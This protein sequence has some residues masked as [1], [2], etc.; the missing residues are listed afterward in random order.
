MVRQ[1]KQFHHFT[2]CLGKWTVFT[3]L[4]ILKWKYPVVEAAVS[5]LCCEARTQRRNRLWQWWM[6]TG[7][8][9]DPFLFFHLDVFGDVQV[10]QSHKQKF[11]VPLMFPP[12]TTT[13]P[14]STSA[15]CFTLGQGE[16][17][18]VEWHICLSL[19]HPIHGTWGCQFFLSFP[20][21]LP[22]L[23]KD[24]S[25]IASSC[26]MLFTGNMQ[27]E[28]GWASQPFWHYSLP[29][30]FFQEF[31][32]GDANPDPDYSGCVL[33][34]RRIDSWGILADPEGK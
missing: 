3:K 24:W 10:H 18:P 32:E 31:G 15:S 5:I 34:S 27:V 8:I 22:S 7:L 6:D 17:S 33:T 21:W 12:P 23:F 1:N 28:G 29:G 4:N 9:H 20:W 2:S 16:P 14:T 26:V 25:N 30:W 13:C 19:S 11:T